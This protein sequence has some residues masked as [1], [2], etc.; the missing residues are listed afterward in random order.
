MYGS[1]F[2]GGS[3]CVATGWLGSS[4]APVRLTN[5][6]NAP[7]S[8]VMSESVSVSNKT[9][10]NPQPAK[11]YLPM[12][13]VPSESSCM[14]WSLNPGEFTPLN[15]SLPRV[16]DFISRIVPWMPWQFKKS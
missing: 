9:S 11:A 5:P 8:I 3:A 4:I 13:I 1:I 2:F 15:T 12:K 14:I 6:E 16:T 7:S 10:E